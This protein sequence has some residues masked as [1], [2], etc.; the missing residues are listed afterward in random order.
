MGKEIQAEE[1]LRD[2]GGSPGG[3]EVSCWKS[4][5][6]TCWLSGS[7]QR[8]CVKRGQL[9]IMCLAVSHGHRQGH[10]PVT[11]SRGLG[12]WCRKACQPDLSCP[13]PS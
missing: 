6:E 9:R 12:R 4:V 11:R 1:P 10:T 5:E 13:D 7:C 8:C 3:L 2:H